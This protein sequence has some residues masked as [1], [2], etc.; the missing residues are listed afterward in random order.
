MGHAMVCLMTN[1]DIN[2]VFTETIEVPLDEVLTYGEFYEH[3][4]DLLP[5]RRARARTSSSSPSS[6]SG[7]SSTEP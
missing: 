1:Y 7:S 5:R 6:G 2:L 3:F 4:S